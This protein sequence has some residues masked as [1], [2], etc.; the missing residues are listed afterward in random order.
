MGPSFFFT[1]KDKKTPRS[2]PSPSVLLSKLGTTFSSSICFVFLSNVS[3]GETLV[4]QCDWFSCDLVFVS[5]LAGFDFVTVFQSRRRLRRAS[6]ASAAAASRRLRSVRWRNCWPTWRCTSARNRRRRRSARPWRR[7]R[8]R[9]R[10]RRWPLPW[11]RPPSK[12]TRCRRVVCLVLPSFFFGVLFS[13]A[14][15]G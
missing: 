8:A 10:R 1:R 2:F 6:A 4:P 7:R 12:R 15:F 14:K 11:R 13:E 9:R 5:S 3:L